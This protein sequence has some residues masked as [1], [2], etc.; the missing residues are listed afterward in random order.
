VATELTNL[1]VYVACAYGEVHSLQEEH[2]RQIRAHYTVPWTASSP[3]YFAKGDENPAI[4]FVL[5]FDLFIKVG[6]QHV[7][8]HADNLR[9]L[10]TQPWRH[11]PQEGD[12]ECFCK[13]SA[14][15]P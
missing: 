2:G 8:Y 13:K 7:S 5:H 12:K 6:D 4:Y 9:V 10:G 3:A 15:V 14:T 11:P 1:S